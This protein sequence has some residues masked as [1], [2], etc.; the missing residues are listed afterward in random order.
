M[1]VASVP[2]LA[3]FGKPCKVWKAKGGFST[4]AGIPFSE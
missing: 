1:S 2:D 3:R 4:A